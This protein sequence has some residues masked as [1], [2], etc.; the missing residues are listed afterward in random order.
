MNSLNSDEKAKLRKRLI[1]LREGLRV[2]VKLPEGQSLGE[3]FAAN[4]LEVISASVGKGKIQEE[5]AG[6]WPMRSEI[7]IVAAMVVLAGRGMAL[8]LPVVIGKTLPLEF[9]RWSPQA[10][11]L[12]KGAFGT[13]HP[14]TSAMIVRPHVVLV[15]LLAFDRQ[16][17]RLGYGGGFY[18]RTLLQMRE[19][20]S[21]V[22]VGVGYAGQELEAV[23]NEAHDQS[24]DWI[25]TET[26]IIHAG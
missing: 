11:R 18:D 12:E 17:H 13:R 10:D 2:S 7:D 14:G 4:L 15:P 9:R 8:S 1:A 24:L 21:V 3:V 16:G 26:E 20:G 19:S 22:A 5:V 23:P 6:Y 25:V